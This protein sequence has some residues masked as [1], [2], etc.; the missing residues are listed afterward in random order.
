MA[1][2]DMQTARTI[3]IEVLNKFDPKRNYA[4]P[5][6]DKLLH[7]TGQRQRATDLVFGTIG[8]QAVIILLL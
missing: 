3:A 8:N 7:K 1:L 5:I 4:G 2:R 6:L